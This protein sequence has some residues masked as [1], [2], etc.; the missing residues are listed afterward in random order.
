MKRLEEKTPDFAKAVSKR[1]FLFD[2]I[3]D[4]VE[5]RDVPIF[6]RSLDQDVLQTAIAFSRARGSDA[7]AYICENMSRRLAEQMDEAIAEQPE[8]S[9]S[10][11]EK[12]EADLI[13][14]LRSQ[15]AAGAITLRAKD[16]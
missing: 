12:A 13:K 4:R 8:V 3:P 15:A 5:A 10:D 2:D 14:A 16:D 7:A 11:G 9:E 1:M 6:T